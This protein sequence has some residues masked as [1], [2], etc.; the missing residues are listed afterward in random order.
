MK[1]SA[2]LAPALCDS[3]RIVARVAAGK[4]LS[5][6]LGH[7]TNGANATPRGALI[8]ITHGT[9]RRYGRVQAIVRELS[10]RGQ[11][12]ALVEALL[13][14]SLYALDSGRY[15]EYTVVDQAVRACALLEKWTAKG[16]VN[17]LLRGFLRERKSLEAHIGV[18]AQAR[19]QHPRWWIDLLNASYP[20]RWQDILIAGNSRPPMGLRVNRRRIRAD[21]YAKRLAESGLLARRLDNDALLLEQAMPVERL[22]GFAAGE[23]SV[24]DVGAQRAARCLQ[25]APGQRVLDACAAPGGKTAHILEVADVDL[26]A[27][28]AD[29]ERSARVAH[30][31]ERLGLAASLVAADCTRLGDWWNGAAFDRVLADVPC[32]ASGVVRRHPD[33]KWLRRAQDI[34][35]FAARQAA[36]LDALW[37]VLAP[38]GKLL[39][40]TC[41]VFPGENEEVVSAFMAR[42]P[43]ARRMSEP[44]GAGAQWLPAPEHD[45]FFYALIAKQA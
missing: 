29:P 6:Q 28:D 18:D 38:D 2:A 3:A 15:A 35:A 33:L 19:Y 36:I 22:P 1:S 23:V 27:L 16:Y 43:G 26:T 4:S 34:P 37:Q 5:D 25:L 10:L 21:E 40:V 39:Y 24:Q 32:S 44:D 14:C 8:D 41:S 42:T 13:W 31:L 20:D 45:G 11:P 7:L 30:N 9:L 17:A 12:D